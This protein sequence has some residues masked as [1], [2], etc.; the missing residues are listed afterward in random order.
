MYFRKW[1][2][3][4]LVGIFMVY[5]IIQISLAPLLYRK[6]YESRWID[7]PRSLRKRYPPLGFQPIS[8]NPQL[9]FDV[10]L[11]RPP[12]QVLSAPDCGEAMGLG[13]L[14]GELRPGG[15]KR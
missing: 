1:P 9:K 6:I 10:V 15:V 13:Y 7:L 3:W 14:A 4:L 2:G 5:T 12:S 8:D 11:L